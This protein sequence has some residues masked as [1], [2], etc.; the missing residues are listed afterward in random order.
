MAQPRSPSVIKCRQ[1]QLG[2]SFPALVSVSPGVYIARK[3]ILL[4]EPFFETTVHVVM[5]SWVMCVK[6]ASAWTVTPERCFTAAFREPDFGSL[7]K[8]AIGCDPEHAQ[9]WT[10]YRW[11]E[12]LPK[13]I[14]VP[15]PFRN[16][17]SKILKMRKEDMSLKTNGYP[18]DISDCIKMRK[19]TVVDKFMLFPLIYDSKQPNEG[20]TAGKG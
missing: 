3:N 5:F 1:L 20:V 11:K 15:K 12:N 2:G 16:M 4:T 13:V 9:W 7:G 18:D 14:T 10:W 6:I 19:Y 8:A 17:Q